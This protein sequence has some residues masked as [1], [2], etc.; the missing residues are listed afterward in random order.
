MQLRITSLTLLCLTLAVIPASAQV[1]YDDGPIN[2]TI[3]AWTINFG[4]IVSDTF[5]LAADST[6]GGFNFGAWVYP[7]DKALTVG[8][9]ITSDEFG[10]TVYG[11]GTASVTD[12]FLSSN[13]YGY[14]VD[15]LSVTGLNV[16]LGAGRYWL[17]LQDATTQM[18][19]PLYWDDNSGVG[20][21]GDDGKGGDCPSLASNNAVGTL[22]SEAFDITG[23]GGGQTPEP[24]SILLLGSGVLAVVGILRRRSF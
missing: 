19:D 21:T 8:W 12:T 24:S 15:A 20:C 23:T 10:G 5:N 22:T 14:Q 6:V 4:Y 18:G 2:G 3:D 13:Q 9:S 1:L 7:G 16:S 17:N 11:S